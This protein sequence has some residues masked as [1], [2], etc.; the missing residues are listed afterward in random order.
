MESPGVG[1][2]IS[3]DIKIILVARTLPPMCSQ[4]VTGELNI[5]LSYGRE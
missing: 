4:L 3:L 1:F 5:R 2:D